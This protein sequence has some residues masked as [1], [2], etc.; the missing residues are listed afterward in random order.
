MKRRKI[1]L[2]RFLIAAV[3]AFNLQAAFALLVSAPGYAAVLDVAGESGTLLVRAVGLLFIMWNIPY[4]FA[5]ADPVRNRSALIEALIM[6]TIGL[7]GETL[8][9]TI[10]GSSLQAVQTILYRYIFFNAG[11]LVL[12][13]IAFYAA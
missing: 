1:T 13:L 5:L 7:A 10:S 3:T 12:L 8:L 6:Q 4:L 2:A 9:L 11:G